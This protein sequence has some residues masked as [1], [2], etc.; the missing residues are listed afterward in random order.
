MKKPIYPREN[1]DTE[2][3]RKEVEGRSPWQQN[4]VSPRPSVIDRGGLMKEMWLVSVQSRIFS[5]KFEGLS[6]RTIWRNTWRT[7]KWMLS[8]TWI[9]QYRSTGI[10]RAFLYIFVFVFT[11]FFLPFGPCSFDPMLFFCSAAL[12]AQ[13]FGVFLSWARLW[14]LCFYT[15]LFAFLTVTLFVHVT[16]TLG[17]RV[18]RTALYSM[19]EN[20]FRFIVFI[21]VSFFISILFPPKR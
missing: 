19:L 9:S 15:L 4:Q 20:R 17:E 6:V 11:F 13:S 14:C 12:M 3:K 1:K 5:P 21:G 2:T 8:Y 18:E 7:L 16:R 10:L